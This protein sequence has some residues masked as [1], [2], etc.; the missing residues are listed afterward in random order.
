MRLMVLLGSPP[1]RRLHAHLDPIL[2]QERVRNHEVGMAVVVHVPKSKGIVPRTDRNGFDRHLPE[3]A[4]Y[5][6]RAAEH[7]QCG[8]KRSLSLHFSHASVIW[9]LE[10]ES[11]HCMRIAVDWQSTGLTRIVL[12]LP[13]NTT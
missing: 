5:M 4:L 1:I 7:S 2:A 3:Q 12:Q 13:L 10:P 8:E 11:E 6:P 9:T